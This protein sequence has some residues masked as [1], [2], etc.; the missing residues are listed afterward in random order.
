MDK[1]NNMIWNTRLSANAYAPM[2]PCV[3]HTKITDPTI[4]A[5]EDFILTP[6]NKAI[7]QILIIIIELMII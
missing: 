6:T 3:R 2:F 1:I 7:K 5:F 4:V